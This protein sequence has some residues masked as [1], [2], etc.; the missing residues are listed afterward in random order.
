MGNGQRHSTTISL[1]KLGPNR[2]KMKNE[3][4]GIP[5]KTIEFPNVLLEDVKGM[6]VW[7]KILRLVISQFYWN[8]QGRNLPQWEFFGSHVLGWLLMLPPDGLPE[9]LRRRSEDRQPAPMNLKCLGFCGW[10]I[11]RSEQPV[12]T[13][14]K[15]VQMMLSSPKDD[16]KHQDR[17]KMF[18]NSTAEQAQSD[19]HTQTTF[20]Q[21]W[22]SKT[23]DILSRS[24]FNTDAGG[25]FAARKHDGGR[26]AQRSRGR[27]AVLHVIFI[28]LKLSNRF[29]RNH[30]FWCSKY[31]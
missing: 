19:L 31:L 4:Q 11:H 6:T 2:W 15:Y 7:L 29:V 25:G 21:L 5:H 26:A 14:E 9:L 20:V 27:V 17:Y 10:M 30:S 3:S 1:A 22:V 12:D 16:E 24:R 23:R 18:T 13:L 28:F 8:N